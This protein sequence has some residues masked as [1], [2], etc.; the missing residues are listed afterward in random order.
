MGVLSLAARLK[1]LSLVARLNVFGGDL[2][3]RETQS[4]GPASS[5][6]ET[7]GPYLQYQSRLTASQNCTISES[8]RG[9]FV[10]EAAIRQGLGGGVEEPKL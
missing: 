7:T 10:V 6:A 1:V 4:V 2:C 5:V 9:S 8:D 3:C